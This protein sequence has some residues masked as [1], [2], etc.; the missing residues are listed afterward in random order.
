[1]EERIPTFIPGDNLAY[2]LVFVCPVNI[3]SVTAAFRNETTGAE[4]V[5]SGEAQLLDRPRVRGARTQAA[6]LGFDTESSEE[7]ETGRYR[8][9]RLEALT[10]GG[11]TLDFDNPPEDAFRFENEPEDATLPRLARGIA[12]PASS[13]LLE[14][15]HP[16]RP[17]ER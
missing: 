11:R 15:G 8:L 1:M 10:Y 16:N 17:V 2:Q 14:Q 12:A 7:P 6:V 4:I 5:I 3:R 9:A 13:F